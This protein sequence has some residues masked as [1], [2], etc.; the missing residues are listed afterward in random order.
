MDKS[1]RRDQVCEQLPR[2]KEI[3]LAI[4][5]GLAVGTYD[6]FFGPG[7]GTFYIVLFCSLLKLD[8]LTASG[9]AKVVNMASNVGA[10][11]T[12][13]VAGKVW[14]LIGIPAA[15]FAIAGNALGSSLAIKNGVKFIRPVMLIVMI[16]LFIKT[17]M[18]LVL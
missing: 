15:L 1:F 8:L 4:L 12:Y 2:S 14:F 9:N 11:F 3:L 6:G 17:I 16:L 18:D 13:L 7:A 10:L 5:I